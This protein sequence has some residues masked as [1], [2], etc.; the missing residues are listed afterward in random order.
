VALS[1]GDG[2]YS[3]TQV[4]ASRHEWAP[5]ATSYHARHQMSP[6]P[7]V[8]ALEVAT[9]YWKPPGE[10]VESL[11]ASRVGRR[12][13]ASW[14]VARSCLPMAT[15]MEGMCWRALL[16]GLVPFRLAVPWWWHM[17]FNNAFYAAGQISIGWVTLTVLFWR[18][19][20][21][22]WKDNHVYSHTK[23][24]THPL[25]FWVRIMTILVEVVRT[26]KVL[27]QIKNKTHQFLHKCNPSLA[28][29]FMHS[30]PTW[31]LF[32]V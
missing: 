14:Q 26:V 5:V 22:C 18:S 12:G 21:I 24:M 1:G 28:E 20:A 29:C 27:R 25:N 10:A 7:K 23:Q 30:Y 2:T 4:C 3:S 13:R 17:E 15:E 19:Y 11:G 32:L 9:Q 6:L 16:P 31:G 8:P